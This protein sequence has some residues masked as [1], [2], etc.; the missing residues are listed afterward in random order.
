M[1]KRHKHPQP[2]ST[3]RWESDI[4][5]KDEEVM[6]REPQRFIKEFYRVMRISWEYNRGIFQFRN[7][8]NC[9]TVFGSARFPED[10][11]YY[12]LG[13]KVGQ[14]LAENNFTVM[15]GGGPGIMEATNRGAKEKGG[16]SIG[17]NIAL[18]EEQKPNIYLD[19]WL[20][21]R[22]FFVRKFL[23][24]KYSSGFIFMPGGFGTLDELFEMLTLEQTGKL[25][26]FPLVLMGKEYWE[27]LMNYIQN[28]LLTQNT[29]NPE[30]VDQLMITDDPQIAVNHIKD[31]LH[32][33]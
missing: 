22:Y 15:T 20:T 26:H 16:Y 7:V 6:L 29:I 28:S 2:T 31:I 13:R 19:K 4:T 10:H 1:H 9:V 3:L 14:T 27:P 5:R 24:T 23:L 11:Y 25:R 8:T 32:L 12:R 17:C 21:F 33:P 18:P 30:D